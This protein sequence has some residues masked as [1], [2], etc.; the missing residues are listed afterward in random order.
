MFDGQEYK[1][2]GKFL[3]LPRQR[4]DHATASQVLLGR[5]EIGAGA[6][7]D[8]GRKFLPSDRTVAKSKCRFVFFEMSQAAVRTE[9]TNLAPLL[10]SSSSTLFD[11]V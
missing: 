8:R 9:C 5:G 2:R 4:I 11:V 1:Q 10:R 6:K 7:P 3:G